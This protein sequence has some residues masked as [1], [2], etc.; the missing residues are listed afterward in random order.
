MNFESDSH[1]V[2]LAAEYWKEKMELYWFRS[3]EEQ[4]LLKGR[5]RPQLPLFSWFIGPVSRIQ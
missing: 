3:G 4:T 5:N 2:S 1:N